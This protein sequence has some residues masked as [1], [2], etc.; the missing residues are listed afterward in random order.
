M[1]TD[2]YTKSKWRPKT[3]K[4]LL[5]Q[6]FSP[7]RSTITFCGD[8]GNATTKQKTASWMNPVGRVTRRLERTQSRSS[9]RVE[10]PAGPFLDRIDSKTMWKSRRSF[11]TFDDFVE[12]GRKGF[13]KIELPPSDHEKIRCKE[14]DLIPSI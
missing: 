8:Y 9:T 4:W 6:S 14:G 1:Q 12:Y 7:R 2:D 5:E 3:S 13:D 11:V 10:R